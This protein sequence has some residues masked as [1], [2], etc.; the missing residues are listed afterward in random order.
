[1]EEDNKVEITENVEPT[2]EEKVEKTFTQSEFVKAL[3]KEVARKTKGLPTKEELDEFTKWKESN[4]SAEDKYL[5]AQKEIDALKGQINEFEKRE[6]VAN[7]DVDPRFQKF[8][9]SEVSQMEGVFEDNLKKYLEDNPQYKFQK[10]IKPTTTGV[11]QKTNEAVD[12]RKEYLDKKYGNNPY[13][14]K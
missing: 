3:E 10:E 2:T 6:V 9:V 4:K 14:K 7:A 5:E 13:Y 1:M 8:V 11:Q 12:E